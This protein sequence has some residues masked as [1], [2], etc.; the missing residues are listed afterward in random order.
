M[1]LM[2]NPPGRGPNLDTFTIERYE[3]IV[4]Y[5]TAF[6]SFV[7][8]VRL[9]NKSLYLFSLSL[10][11]S[12]RKFCPKSKDNRV[13]AKDLSTKAAVCQN[14]NREKQ[15]SNPCFYNKNHFYL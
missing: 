4:K 15:V 12:L 10:T 7:L 8:P 2:S 3:T 9:G 1:D 5:K 13:N 11:N 6:Y 14:K